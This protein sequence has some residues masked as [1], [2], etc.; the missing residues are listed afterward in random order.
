MRDYVDKIIAR[1]RIIKRY[2]GDERLIFIQAI[3]C[4]KQHEIRNIEVETVE[5]A[6]SILLAQ[7]LRKMLGLKKQLNVFFEPLI[8][9]DI[10][11]KIVAVIPHKEREVIIDYKGKGWLVHGR[12]EKLGRVLIEMYKINDQ[13]KSCITYQEDKNQYLYKTVDDQEKELFSYNI[14]DLYEIIMKVDY[15]TAIKELCK[16]Y[17]IRISEIEKEQ[18]LYKRNREAINDIFNNK[19]HL[20]IRK[21]LSDLKDLLKQLINFAEETLYNRSSKKVEYNHVR[22]IWLNK[23]NLE[24]MIHKLRRSITIDQVKRKIKRLQ[25]L[26]FITFVS[27][28]ISYPLIFYFPEYNEVFLKALTIRIERQ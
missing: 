10:T 18:E 14:I 3:N 24:C 2:I 22:Y 1:K 5:Q 7:D 17:S 21:E 26:G 27:D 11:V 12:Q 6:R 28:N 23:Y 16:I 19:E 25:E 15:Y 8:A 9:Q 13:L 20:M 4:F